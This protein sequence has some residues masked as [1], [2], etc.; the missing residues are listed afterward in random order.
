MLALVFTLS[1]ALPANTQ[2]AQAPTAKQLIEFFNQLKK[3]STEGQPQ[4]EIPKDFREQEKNREEFGKAL[5][6]LTTP[7]PTEPPSKIGGRWLSLL[8]STLVGPTKNYGNP[9]A[10]LRA[11]PHPDAWP[12]I[13]AG[14]R[15]NFGSRSTPMA[16]SLVL[17]GELLGGTPQ[18]QSVAFA[19][20]KQR[21]K[22][23]TA[24]SRLES[25]Q[26]ALEPEGIS[27]PPKVLTLTRVL[28]DAKI[29]LYR[30]EIT[31]AHWNL[32]QQNRA[33]FFKKLFTESRATFKLEG[34]TPSQV[35]Q[36]VGWFKETAPK[37]RVAQW[38]MVNE[39]DSHQLF[40]IIAKRF[41]WAPKTPNG[42]IKQAAV[43]ARTRHLF[44]LAARGEIAKAVSAAGDGSTLKLQD[45]D[46]NYAKYPS[47]AKHNIYQFLSTVA[48]RSPGSPAWAGMLRFAELN[49]NLIGFE[50]QVRTA[51]KNSKLNPKQRAS[52]QFHHGNVLLKLDQI[53]PALPPLKSAS[54]SETDDGWEAQRILGV[55]ARLLKRPELEPATSELRTRDRSTAAIFDLVKQGKLDEV[56]KRILN[57]SSQSF[58]PDMVMFELLT[59]AVKRVDGPTVLE[60]VN[61]FVWSTPGFP[62]SM[63][64]GYEMYD[65]DRPPSLEDV[66]LKGLLES[67][68]LAEAGEIARK[69]L[70]ANPNDDDA[71]IALITAE[72]DAAIPLLDK[73]AEADPYQERPLIWK[74]KRLQMSGK[75][76]EAAAVA[77]AAIKIDPSDGES[78][79]GRRMVVYS[80]YADILEAQGHTEDAQLYRNAVAAVRKSED[81]DEFLELGMTQRA[82]KLYKE[83]LD[84]FSDA[85][86]IQSRLAHQLATMGRRAEALEHYRKAYE[87]MSSSFG[88]VETHCFGCE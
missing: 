42:E 79:G 59:E 72:G 28:N 22:S 54:K 56:K 19:K 67:G 76:D 39:L 34:L 21:A 66:Y 77:K 74:A 12:T 37:H 7:Y 51:L 57:E 69:Q 50:S 4:F 20:L 26:E 31:Q 5:L 16:A 55:L 1:V 32:A 36:L 13:A 86:C 8:D 61:G 17:Y 23:P 33:Q 78:K 11:V 83:S 10:V 80:V 81:A 38:E 30:F 14:L 41:A 75:L 70:Y 15:K 40:P 46:G 62:L 47:K 29:E 45:D 82:V 49:G 44:G 52:L 84:Q 65:E 18:S 9:S 27:S 43:L 73:L 25:I 53:E 35:A 88:Y 24:K 64:D 3:E 68:H 63:R 58:V 60:I 71:L 87:L 6:S 48:K 2:Q 85:Y